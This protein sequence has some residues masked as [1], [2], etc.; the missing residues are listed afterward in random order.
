MSIESRSP[1]PQFAFRLKRALGG[2]AGWS[3]VVL[4]LVFV[5]ILTWVGAE[6]RTTL[7]TRT[8]YV[9]DPVETDGG[10]AEAPKAP[11]DRGT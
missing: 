1:P 11:G 2:K 5:L 4:Q 3:G 10:T 8:G 9:D 6:I 7:K